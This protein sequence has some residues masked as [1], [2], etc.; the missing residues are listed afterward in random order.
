MSVRIELVPF[1]RKWAALYSREERRIRHCLG[2]RVRSLEHVGSTSVP[3]L[4]AKPVIDIVL[5]VSDSSD[6]TSYLPDLRDAGY[7]VRLREP[8]WYEH[9]LLKGPDTDINLH[10]FSVGCLEI[11]RMILFRDQL[12]R[13]AEDRERYG[14]VKKTL[15]G[16]AWS[17]VQDY[18]DAKTAIVT[19]ILDGAS[20]TE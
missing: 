8:G 18:A 20:G 3:G 15:A 11:E 12:R 13:S 4:L 1:D 6:E 7:T 19:S 14:E 2:Y 16:R 5:A 10:V 17:S 9:R